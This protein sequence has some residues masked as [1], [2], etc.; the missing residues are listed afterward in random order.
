MSSS[1]TRPAGT[2][3]DGTAFW[4][5]WAKVLV[6]GDYLSPVELPAISPGGSPADLPGDARPLGGP[7]DAGRMGRPR[8]RRTDLRRARPGG[9]RSRTA[10]TSTRSRAIATTP[11]CLPGEGA[12]HGDAPSAADLTTP[13]TSRPGSRLADATGRRDLS[14]SRARNAAAAGDSVSLARGDKHQLARDRGIG[15]HPDRTAAGAIEIAAGGNSETPTPSATSSTR[16]TSVS[17]SQTIRRCSPTA[18]AGAL[19]AEAQRRVRAVLD[20]RS[21]RRGRSAGPGCGAPAD[22]RRRPRAAATRRRSRRARTRS[23]CG[24]ERQIDDRQ[25]QLAIG[26]LAHE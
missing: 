10:P 12:A 25:L 15:R 7:G 23:P 16:S 9:A 3:P 6:C 20:E 21:G 18:L 11:H 26:G 2:P 5:P 14:S 13:R 8:S 17:T 1:C 4:L 24:P 22:R 19:D